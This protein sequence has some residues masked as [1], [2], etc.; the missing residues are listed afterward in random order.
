MKIS[1]IIPTYNRKERLARGLEALWN[2]EFDKDECEVIVVDDGSTDGT[3]EWIGTIETPETL[4]YLWHENVGRAAN[5][6]IG[7]RNARGELIVFLDDD[8]V[9]TPTLLTEHFKVHRKESNPRL[10]VL[11][12][13]PFGANVKRNSI[14]EYCKKSWEGIFENAVAKRH[15]HPYWFFITNNLSV[16]RSFVL[17]VGLFDEDFKNYSYEDSEL[18]YRLHKAGMVLQFNRAALAYHN[19][20]MDLEKICKQ[21]FQMGYSAVIYYSKHRE[22]KEELSI[23]VAEGWTERNIGLKR[24]AWRVIKL[25]FYNDATIGLV[26][27]F[28]RLC[29]PIMSERILFFLYG[30]MHWHHYVKGLRRGLSET[31]LP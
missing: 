16:R 9:A 4:K 8:V 23:N 6:N 29:G 13:T 15:D 21:S 31:R 1:V 5:R 24:K 14:T 25:L 17:S 30:V 10:V 12:Y 7:I 19:F 3:R 22:L 20:E 28:L 11:G 27:D 2:Q 18:G 26:K